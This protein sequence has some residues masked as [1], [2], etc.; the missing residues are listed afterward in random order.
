MT[1]KIKRVDQ[2]TIHIRRRFHSYPFGSYTGYTV[3]KAVQD[4]ITSNFPGVDPSKVTVIYKG[5][6]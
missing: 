6:K 4:Y 3:R 2:H 1:I 5:G